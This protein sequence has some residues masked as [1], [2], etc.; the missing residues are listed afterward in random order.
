MGRVGCDPDLDQ[1]E[2]LSP[3][4]LSDRNKPGATSACSNAGPSATATTTTQSVW[5]HTNS[6]SSPTGTD[7]FVPGS[8]VSS[9]TAGKSTVHT[10]A[11]TAVYPSA[12]TAVCTSTAETSTDNISAGSTICSSTAS[13]STSNPTTVSTN[14]CPTT[15]GSETTTSSTQTTSSTTSSCSSADPGSIQPVLGS[16]STNPTAATKATAT[17]ATKATHPVPGTAKGAYSSPKAASKTGCGSCS[18]S[19][20]PPTPETC[21]RTVS[22]PPR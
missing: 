18:G 11:A 4:P 3:T 13:T 17:A 6:W 16:E 14:L 1:H 22:F 10:S 9:T 12:A 19:C 15:S 8:T 5:K 7:I 2:T 20:S 21:P